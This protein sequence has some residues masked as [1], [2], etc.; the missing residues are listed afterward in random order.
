MEE[1]TPR[2]T[3]SAGQD[4]SIYNPKAWDGDGTSRWNP[5]Q[6]GHPNYLTSLQTT[7]LTEGEIRGRPRW[8]LHLPRWKITAMFRTPKT[9]WGNHLQGI[10][11]FLMVKTCCTLEDF[12]R[13]LIASPPP[14]QKK[15]ER[16]VFKCPLQ[17]CVIPHTKKKSCVYWYIIFQAS[18]LKVPILSLQTVYFDQK[19]FLDSL[20]SSPHPPRKWLFAGCFTRTTMSADGST[21]FC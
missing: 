18:Y 5:V 9:S 15:G 14:Y 8:H 11:W 16:R 3:C 2:S 1:K 10:R 7:N 20:Q 17:K 6:S 12:V 13:M 21:M 4:I 19:T